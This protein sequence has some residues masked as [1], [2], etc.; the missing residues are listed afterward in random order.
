M[1]IQK[2]LALLL[3]PLVFLGCSAALAQTDD[4]DYYVAA[5]GG[6]HRQLWEKPL[7]WDYIAATYVRTFPLKRCFKKYVAPKT[8]QSCG[9]KEKTCFFGSQKGECPTPLPET[10]CTCDGAAGNQTWTCEDYP[11]CPTAQE[12]PTVE[13]YQNGDRSC[14]TPGNTCSFEYEDG[15]DQACYITDTCT[16]DGE[17]GQL[18][19]ESSTLCE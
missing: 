8:D 16:C 10:K 5:D 13:A 7:W 1:L 15:T 17:S 19:C 6:E 9:K 18:D 2:F 4:D 12:C 14:L 3:L 11:T